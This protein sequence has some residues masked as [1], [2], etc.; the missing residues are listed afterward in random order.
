MASLLSEVV[1][2]LELDHIFKSGE[3]LYFGRK[4]IYSNIV[5]ESKASSSDQVFDSKS[6]KLK[7]GFTAIKKTVDD[8][9][10]ELDDFP[11]TNTQ[12]EALRDDIAII[13]KENQQFRKELDELHQLLKNITL[14]SATTAEKVP[15]KVV[16]PK[17]TTTAA[18]D[19]FDLFDSD[20]EEEAEEQK[21]IREER[22]AA[23]A[24][25]KSKKPGPIAKSSVILDVKPWDDET[26]MKEME[27][28]VRS[29]E[30]DGLLWGAAKFI[31]I[32]YGVQKLQIV[33]TIEDAKVSVDDDLI[34][35]IQE[36]FS[37]HVQSVDI[38]AF[39]K[40]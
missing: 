15:V 2:N 19:D 35:R 21:R 4:T 20:E 3:Q 25:K 11:H 29:I 37:D 12:L 10:N 33:S 38:V 31:P 39:N 13:K 18:D 7:E 23:Y 34:E 32:G 28:L 30:L 36:K 1:P 6:N 5:T 17:T 9:I 26:D 14:V 22:L 8:A 40:I 27:R 16:V 24:A